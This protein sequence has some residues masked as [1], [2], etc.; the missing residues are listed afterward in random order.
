MIGIAGEVVVLVVRALFVFVCVADVSGFEREV[1]VVIDVQDHAPVQAETAHRE[2]G[3]ADGET[4]DGAERH[5]AR[6]RTSDMVLPAGV[7]V[8]DTRRP[9][10]APKA[11]LAAVGPLGH[12]KMSA[13]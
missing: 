2:D 4:N 5:R 10:P 13:G 6:L 3:E 8:K 12:T 11:D 1:P 9:A 7:G